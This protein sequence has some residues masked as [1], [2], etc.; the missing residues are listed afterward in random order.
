MALL[1]SLLV[2]INH[3]I[4]TPYFFPSSFNESHKSSNNDLCESSPISNVPFGPSCPNLVPCPPA[5]VTA[6][7]FP[8][9]IAFFPMLS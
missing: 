1:F 8:S 6:A 4:V 2:I 9:L 5:I 7:S 3:G